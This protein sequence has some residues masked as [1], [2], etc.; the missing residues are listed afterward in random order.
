MLLKESFSF[1]D[2]HYTVR[3]YIDMFG[4]DETNLGVE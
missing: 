3:R 2:A 4:F 1:R